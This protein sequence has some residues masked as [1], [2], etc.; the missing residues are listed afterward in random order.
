MVWTPPPGV[1][2][3]RRGRAPSP[4][5]LVGVVAVGL[6]AIGWLV[7]K[8][9]L[10]HTTAIHDRR[11]LGRPIKDLEDAGVNTI[12]FSPD[13]RTLAS[14]D[15]QG[16]VRLWDVR[17]HRQVGRPLDNGPD[18]WSIS[19]VRFSPD[20]RLRASDNGSVVRLW[21]VRSR[22]LA[23]S[24][25]ANTDVFLALALSPNGRILAAGTRDNLIL[26]CNIRSRRLLAGAARP[27]PYGPRR[28]RR[29]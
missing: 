2:L 8:V 20:G 3:L 16:T 24:L 13:G 12:A 4:F 21:N 11:Q 9:G 23:P 7:W 10:V 1:T 26:L 25:T 19:N 22:R 15:S 14:G 17:T 27:H 29:L 5:L 28:Q 6:V 18:G